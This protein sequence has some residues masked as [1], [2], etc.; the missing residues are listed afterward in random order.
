MKRLIFMLNILIISSCFVAG[1]NDSGNV[2]KYTPDFKFEEGIFMNFDQV[3][4]NNPIPRSRIFTTIDY[5][6]PYFYDKLLEAKKIY[7]YDQLG[8]KQELL[9]RNIWGY[10]KN[11]VLYINISGNYFRITIIGNICH[12][13]ATQ[14]TYTNNYYDPYYSNMYRTY[15][16]RYNPQ[17]YQSTEMRQY[18]LDFTTGKILDYDVQSLEVLLMRDPELYDEYMQLRK[19]KKKQLKFLFLRKFNERNPLYFPKRGQ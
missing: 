1:Q 6:S 10:S 3:K 4:K 13:V 5:S 15:P 12:F 18:L 8:T 2:I 7:F 14:T 19:K 16:Y 9:T 17:T 11:G